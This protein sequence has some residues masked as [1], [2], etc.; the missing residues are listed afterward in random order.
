MFFFF[1]DYHAIVFV[2]DKRFGLVGTQEEAERYS[3]RSR[4][5][6]SIVIFPT[7]RV[8]LQAILLN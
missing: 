1:G 8:I 6:S 2:N 4:G 3:N 5:K 7:L